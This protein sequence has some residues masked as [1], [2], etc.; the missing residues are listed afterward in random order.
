MSTSTPRTGDPIPRMRHSTG[1]WLIRKEKPLPP[2]KPP[3]RPPAPGGINAPGGTAAG[4]S[5]ICPGTD[6]ARRPATRATGTDPGAPGAVGV[7]SS[8][9]PRPAGGGAIDETSLESPVQKVLRRPSALGGKSIYLTVIEGDLKGKSF[10][11]TGLG[12]YTMGRRDCDIVLEDEKVSRKHASIIIVQADKYSVQDL[13]SRNGTF[14][15]GVRLTR[16]NIQHNDLI[17]IG[18]C[19]LRFTVFDGPVPVE[20]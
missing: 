9:A 5:M 1:A 4:G 8:V 20:K 15:N 2:S 3:A 10:D 14:V 19:T 13:A 7:P 6:G 16:R 17:R 11:I 18:N 12:T